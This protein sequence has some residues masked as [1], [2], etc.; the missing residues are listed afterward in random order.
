MRISWFFIW[1][2]LN[3]LHPRMHW[4]R[5][6]LNFRYF[7]IISC[8][9]RRSPS[10]EQTW[11]PFTEGCIAPSLFEIGQVVLEKKIFLNLVN[12]LLLLNYNLPL[13][14]S[15]SFNQTWNLIIQECFVPSLVEIDKMEKKIFEFRHW[16]FFVII[17]PLKTAGPFIW[18][19]LNPP[20]PKMH[21]AKFGLNW[22][23]CYG[24]KD[25]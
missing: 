11:I 23:S 12:V 3:S 24:E 10:F 20:N 8:C 6:L 5:R 13:G 7:V 2:N 19:N 16:V 18:S 25:F 22:S 17:S 15:T 9:K 14:L 21:S 4:R 1:A